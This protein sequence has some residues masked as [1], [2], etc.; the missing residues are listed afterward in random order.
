MSAD[1]FLNIIKTENGYF[2]MSGCASTGETWPIKEFPTRDE[3]IDYANNYM[4]EN[5]VEYGIINISK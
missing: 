3:A 5:V 1:N 2:V 4:A